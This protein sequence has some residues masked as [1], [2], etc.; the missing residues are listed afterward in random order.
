MQFLE[1]NM[2][3]IM[4]GTI[5]VLLLGN[6]GLL[7]YL[8][9]RLT[10]TS[11]TSETL[12]VFLERI[13]VL[14]STFQADIARVEKT[15]RDEIRA[16]QEST[17][18]SLVTQL[19]TST[20][21]LVKAVGEI[22][23]GQSQRLDAVTK[24]INT[25]TQTNESRIAE[26]KKTLAEG[27]QQLQTSNEKKLD[28]I[29]HTVD[30]Q[31]QTTL[32]SRI[33]ESFKLVSR[34]LESVQQGLGEMQ[35]LA[36][37]VGDLKKVL[38]NVRTRGTWGE[39]RL[40]ALLEQILTPDQYSANVNIKSD[41]RE[42]VEFAIRL[43]GSPESLDRNVWLPIDSKFPVAD[44]ERLL[45]AS[46]AKA[47]KTLTRDFL[48]GIETEAKKIREKYVYPPKTTD[49]AIMFLPTEGLYA[50]VLRQPGM[51]TKLQTTYRVVVA[52]PTT[53]AAILNSLRM[54]FQTLTIQQRSSEVWEVLAA[55]K[56][57]FEKFGDELN[58][59]ENQLKTPMNTI[60]RIHTRTRAMERSLR[61]VEELPSDSLE[62]QS[63][64]LDDASDISDKFV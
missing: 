38:T 47:E 4:L 19:G 36:T 46:D 49:F 52:G 37:G 53:L 29:R 32:E 18:K 24:A 34:H 17:T 7:A 21:S 54:G 16:S 45:E 64:L 60:G 13:A 1:K 58:K 56:S 61:A 33:T 2:S 25:L 9:K 20:D 10:R 3:N 27:L 28:S 35:N 63:G 26:V 51:V 12:T 50:E 55:V 22:G 30:E 57:E 31:L 11:E 42:S 40:R 14:E 48:K 15:M 43:P 6:L 44:Y 39:T 62:T 23:D 5:I 8:F 59:L 41:T